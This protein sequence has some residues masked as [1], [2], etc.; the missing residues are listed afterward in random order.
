[1]GNRL[2]DMLESLNIELI[3]MGALCEDA[4]S[5]A[6]KSLKNHEGQVERDTDKGICVLSHQH[7]N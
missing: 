6:T 3:R 1:M 4:I 7:L 5:T 2:D